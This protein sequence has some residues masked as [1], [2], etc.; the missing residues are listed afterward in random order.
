M[1]RSGVITWEA[2]QQALLESVESFPNTVIICDDGSETYLRSDGATGLGI[3]K[4]EHV[5]SQSEAEAASG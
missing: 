3:A 4:R 5:Q 2:F 1:K